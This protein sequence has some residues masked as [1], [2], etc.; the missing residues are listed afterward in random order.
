ML[1]H[2][3]ENSLLPTCKLSDFGSASSD[4][5]HRERSESVVMCL[6]SRAVPVA[7]MHA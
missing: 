7:D 2:W 6:T 3:E 5:H 4:S 1:L